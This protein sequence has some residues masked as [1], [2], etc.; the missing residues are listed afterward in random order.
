MRT[1]I[2]TI[3]C[4]GLAACGEPSAR[5]SA[6]GHFKAT[7]WRT[8]SGVPHVKADDLGSLGFGLGFANAEDRA[9]V[10]ADQI[11]KVRSERARVFGAGVGDANVD[12]DLVY[13]ALRIHAQAEAE[14]P[15]LPEDVRALLQGYAEGYNHFL[16]SVGPAGLPV[17]C[18]GAT[19]VEPISATDLLAYSLD[20]AQRQGAI[21]LLPFIARAEPPGTA[22]S[23]ESSAPAPV[24]RAE[25]GS[26]GW[27]IGRDRAAG[28]QGMLLANPH[29]PWE[30]ELALYEA[31]LI[32]PGMMNV[33]GAMLPGM[34]A[35]LI[36]FN[37]DVAWTH[38]VTPARHAAVYKLRLVPGE[39][40]H[41]WFDGE[42]R[43]MTSEEYAVPVK[44][45][46]G[47]TRTVS[48]RF[49]RSHHGPMLGGKSFPWTEQV[50]FSLRDAN[51]GNVRVVEQWLRMGM[52]SSLDA[53]EAIQTEVHASPWVFTL[54]VSRDGEASIVDA[55]RVLA[56]SHEAESAYQKTLAEDA[57]AKRLAEQGFVLL[58]GSSARDEWV[59]A[60]E[61]GALGLIPVRE[62]PHLRRT[63]FVMNA[64]EPPWLA[65][66]A[67]PL[68][69]Y[70]MLY[71]PPYQPLPPRTQ[72]NLHLLTAQGPGAASGADGKFSLNELQAAVLDNRGLLAERL[73]A[74]VVDR[75]E[76]AEGHPSADVREACDALRAWDR[77]LDLNSTGALVWREFLGTFP[78]EALLDAGE[79]FRVPFDPDN[80][81]T[82]PHTLASAPRNAPDPILGRLG[83]AVAHLRQA[84]FDA[85]TKLGD[86]QFTKMGDSI[87][88]IHGG[89]PREGV[90]NVVAYDAG[91]NTT[92]LPRME[93]MDVLR[94][95]TG[96]T[97]EGY[98][99]NFGTSFLMALEYTESG[100]QAA[101]LHSHG[102]SND[103]ASPH[104]LEET[105]RFSKKAWRR[106]LFHEDEIG[107][108][109]ALRVKEISDDR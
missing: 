10:I 70:P 8:G 54:A 81:L 77:R 64:N 76:A 38:T 49:Y 84:G 12:S 62:A 67:E 24:E 42:I 59:G 58:D 72:M 45:S 39:P 44:A 11:L 69:N 95:S 90:L 3:V 56:L 66:P 71:G 29:F 37:E 30:G 108:D 25:I 75:C 40:T 35:I 53:L 47:S 82:T 96:L 91:S 43:T 36:G 2:V 106:A 33:Y 86:A 14:F 92:L 78:A 87:I 79:L 97:R 89:G 107:A 99:V 13:L 88:P 101:V 6:P 57:T 65:N 63:D 4:V 7:V 9:C 52:A 94:E 21:A 18:T 61:H 15:R 32:V 46:D 98:L 68:V 51:A 19:W 73:Y 41:Y 26:N 74:Q 104:Y 48:R 105:W 60:S 85:W 50:A 102:G 109:P 28:G 22:P 55:S 17:P 103:P 34:P 20:L 31:H 16:G 23:E 1:V 100:P 83:E 5:S 27:A 80:P 93:R